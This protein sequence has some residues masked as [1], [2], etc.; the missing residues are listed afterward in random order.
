MRILAAIPTYETIKPETF[1]SVYGLRRAGCEVLFDFVRGYGAA[2]ARNLIAEE[3]LSG[4]FDAVLMV[5]SDIVLPSDA[6]ELLL[7]G[8]C[9]VVLGCYP[10]RGEEGG[11][12]IFLPGM[13]DFTDANRVM[14]EHLPH[15]RFEAKGGGMGCALIRAEA[16]RSLPR[17][18]F[19]YV[20]YPDGAVLS[21]DNFFCCRCS[22]HGIRI[23]ADGRVRCGHVG[24]V[25]WTI[26]G[27]DARA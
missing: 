3:A 23:E 1:K 20:E 27:S 7:E 6:L 4:G 10:R 14:A 19:D 11:T 5:D 17:P 13:R 2:R 25:E 21:E 12:E 26:G 22:E 8:D 24:A 16:L 18:W 15:G 9:P